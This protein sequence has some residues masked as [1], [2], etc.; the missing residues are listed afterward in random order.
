M[1]PDPL[2]L[3]H[4][5]LQDAMPK[6]KLELSQTD[7][8]PGFLS[9]DVNDHS[10]KRSLWSLYAPHE[11][12][13]RGSGSSVS[14]T[15]PITRLLDAVTFGAAAIAVVCVLTAGLAGMAMTIIGDKK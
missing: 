14:A 6:R 7:F 3:D 9:Q 1:F 13:A 5:H 4:P 15:T 8:K 12:L 10:H 2:S 11:R